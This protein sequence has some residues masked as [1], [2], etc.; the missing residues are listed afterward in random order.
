MFVADLVRYLSIDCEV[1]FIKISS[2]GSATTTSGT[3]RLIKDISAD[4]T[5]RHVIVVEDI[6]D[7]GLTLAFLRKRMLE[8][9]PKSLSIATFLL[10]P[11]IAKVDFEIDWIGFEIENKFVVGYGLDYDQKYRGLTS[12]HIYDE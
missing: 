7:T 12:I 6:V 5:G 1:D 10:K 4:I 3:V 9:N 8:T 2:Y 11:E